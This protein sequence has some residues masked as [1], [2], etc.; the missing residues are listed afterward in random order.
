[1]N[2]RPNH[3][4]RVGSIRTSPIA[5]KSISARDS[6]LCWTGAVDLYPSPKTMKQSRTCMS[7]RFVA[8]GSIKWL[9]GTIG[10]IDVLTPIQTL[11]R[12]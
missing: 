6:T 10:C 9:S 3:W 1:M 2:R 12:D 5:K 8:G 4:K 11:T 7:S